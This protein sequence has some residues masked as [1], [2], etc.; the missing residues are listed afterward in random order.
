MARKKDSGGWFKVYSSILDDPAI[1]EIGNEG[2]GVYIRILAMLNRTRSADGKLTV[3]DAGLC[4]LSGRRRIDVSEKTVR[5]LEEVG[6]SS[7]ERLGKV[8]EITVPKW[9]IYLGRMG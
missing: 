5:L 9:S 7:L 3:S 4:A 6:L 2:L 1:G 8:W